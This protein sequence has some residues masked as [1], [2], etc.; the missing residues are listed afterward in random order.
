MDTK[1]VIRRKSKES[2]LTLTGLHHAMIRG[3]ATV[4]YQTVTAWWTGRR[5]P[6]LKNAV[7]LARVLGIT[8]E[9]LAGT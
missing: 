7:I 3:G 4:S 1:D 6:L 5:E 9:E 2:G 8:V